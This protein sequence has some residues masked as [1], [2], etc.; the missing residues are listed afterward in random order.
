MVWRLREFHATLQG[1][2]NKLWEDAGV[3]AVAR[4]A[5]KP[6]KAQKSRV[7]GARNCG[8]LRQVAYEHVN[9][10]NRPT[11]ERMDN[12]TNHWRTLA[13][14]DE[15]AENGQNGSA[16]AAKNLSYY[17]L[18]VRCAFLREMLGTR[19]QVVKMSQIGSRDRKAQAV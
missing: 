7:E 12:R 13:R 16:M 11:K 4:T 17:K 9:A 3:G 5:E 8:K 2:V 19:L 18:L 10:A 15:T 1:Q 14:G 6:K